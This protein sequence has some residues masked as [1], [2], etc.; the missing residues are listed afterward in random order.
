MTLFRSAA[1][2]CLLVVLISPLHSQDKPKPKAP[3]PPGN[4]GAPVSPGVCRSTD[5]L[6]CIDVCAMAAQMAGNNNSKPPIRLEGPKNH[7]FSLPSHDDVR[8]PE[9]GQ[10]IWTCSSK[11][12]IITS[13]DPV[14]NPDMATDC[15][16]PDPEKFPFGPL[17][18][19][20]LNVPQKAGSQLKSGPALSAAIG[21]WYQ[22]QFKLISGP[23]TSAHDEK[24]IDPHF[25]VTGPPG[26]P[27]S[28][29]GQPCP[30]HDPH[31]DPAKPP[32]KSKQ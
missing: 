9:G 15:A 21:Q 31:D 8:V 29:R 6:K 18:K 4:A 1:V 7:N 19:T 12:F 17:E 11:G 3:T 27:E 23:R 28:K 25:I 13:I 32:A 30:H 2:V 20:Y 14:W 5:K 22:Y 10:I 16:H 26:G 24:T